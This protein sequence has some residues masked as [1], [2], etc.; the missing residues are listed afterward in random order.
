M[1]QTITENQFEAEVL[2]ADVPV[3]VDFYTPWCGPC[4]RFAPI[5]EDLA[6]EAGGR[7]KIVTVDA[8]QEP[9]LADRFQVNSV[10]TLLI[11]DGGEATKKLL[12][13]QSREA[14]LAALEVA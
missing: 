14:I 12:G 8:E 6:A 10:P 1:T 11:F 3:L 9:A 5:I 13:V 7:F 4:K 2:Q